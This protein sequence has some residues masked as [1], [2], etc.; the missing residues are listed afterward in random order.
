ML[1]VLLS[2]SSMQPSSGAFSVQCFWCAGMTTALVVGMNMSYC[3]LLTGNSL[4]CSLV[5]MFIACNHTARGDDLYNSHCNYLTEP[6]QREW[7][8]REERKNFKFHSSSYGSK[9]TW[10]F[11][12]TIKQ[13]RHKPKHNTI[14]QS[15]PQ[16]YSLSTYHC[17][18][19]QS[20]PSSIQ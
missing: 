18:P 10:A 7:T 16:C 4:V 17:L 9:G 5:R 20:T 13:D 15:Q 1:V 3:W 6:T 11:K 14:N 2:V 12:F 19:H 8:Q